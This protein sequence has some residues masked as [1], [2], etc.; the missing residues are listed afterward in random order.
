MATQDFALMLHCK[1]DF[2][3]FLVWT[4]FNAEYLEPCLM[5]LWLLTGGN[6]LFGDWGRPRGT[7][8]KEG[9]P[10]LVYL[11]NE[12]ESDDEALTNNQHAF[13]Q[14]MRDGHYLG[15]W[16]ASDERPPQLVYDSVRLAINYELLYPRWLFL[17]DFPPSQL[18]NLERRIGQPPAFSGSAEDFVVPRVDPV[19]VVENKA[20]DGVCAVL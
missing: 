11:A 10:D 1:D 12:F 14:L 19:V 20:S 5:S 2:R 6:V 8:E 16:R 4:D 18:E 7:E 17:W 3:S 15:Y 13:V 9:S